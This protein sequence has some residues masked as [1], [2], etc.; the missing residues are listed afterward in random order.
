MLTVG[1]S[2]G[3]LLVGVPFSGEYQRDA[4]FAVAAADDEYGSILI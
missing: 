4:L 3:W 1:P 2:V